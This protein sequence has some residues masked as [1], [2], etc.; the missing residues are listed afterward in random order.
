MQDDT[1]SNVKCNLLN[2]NNLSKP[3]G[4]EITLTYSPT[5]KASI[6][7]SKLCKSAALTS[8]DTVLLINSSKYAFD[9]VN[10]LLASV[11]SSNI[12]FFS[13]TPNKATA[14]SS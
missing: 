11:T 13:I 12:T 8:I 1:L 7:T 6:F 2:K 4:L 9:F 14:A 5:R 10:K 3:C